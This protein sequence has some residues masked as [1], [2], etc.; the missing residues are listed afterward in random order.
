M[1]NATQSIDLLNLNSDRLTAED[2]EVIATVTV[3]AAIGM[4]GWRDEFW[5]EGIPGVEWG[6]EG[7]DTSTGV[8]FTSQ[9]FTTP[10][11]HWAPQIAHEGQHR[12]DFLMKTGAYEAGATDRGVLDERRALI[13]QLNVYRRLSGISP[14]VAPL[15]PYEQMLIRLIMRPHSR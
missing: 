13:R 5:A 12:R 3:I 7:I 11:N 1:E 9:I 14:G 4:L 8:F 6:V 15:D 10:A 2:H